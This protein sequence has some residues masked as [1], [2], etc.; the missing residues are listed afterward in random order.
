[1]G[2][3]SIRDHHIAAAACWL[4]VAAACPA[5][6]TNITHPK[7]STSLPA[8]LLLSFFP[9]CLA[10][11][12]PPY[13][14]SLSS[15]WHL[16]LQ[17][18][19]PTP[20]SPSAPSLCIPSLRTLVAVVA[21]PSIPAASQPPPPPPPPPASSFSSAPA[22][23]GPRS[24]HRIAS[25]HA[26]SHLAAALAAVA[27]LRS[28]SPPRRIVRPRPTTSPPAPPTHGPC[29]IP[30]APSLGRDNAPPAC[31]AFL[32]ATCRPHTPPPPLFFIWSIVCRV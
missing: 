12:A 5:P 14:R 29:H 25:H 30:L 21:V 26:G 15:T 7:R 1:M 9:S 24:R 16:D 8:C 18:L 20:P 31:P 23:L 4:V 13:P 17:P 10:R 2:R 32:P 28:S 11:P 19:P 6:L 22:L 27:A 3:A